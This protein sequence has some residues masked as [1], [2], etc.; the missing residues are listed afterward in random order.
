MAQPINWDELSK[1]VLAGGAGAV[2]E[3]LFG[4]PEFVAKKIDRKKVEDWIKANAPAYHTGEAIGTVGSMFVPYAG[5]A[6]KAAKGLGLGAE[7]AKGAATAAKTAA[8][9]TDLTRGAKLAKTLKTIG[10]MAGKGAAAGATEAGVRGIT[11]EKS[12]KDIAKDIQSGAIWGGAGGAVGGALAKTLPRR[13]GEMTKTAEQAYLGSTDLTRREALQML[14]TWPGRAIR[15]LGNSRRPIMPARN[16]SESEK[17]SEH[18]Y[19][20]KWTMRYLHIKQCGRCL[21]TSSKKQCRMY[22]VRISTARPQAK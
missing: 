17:K 12:L 14:K 18:I 1:S 15:A 9:A 22:A 16:L 10:T 2:D 6:G 21:M 13:A 4:L 3:F 5:L 8:V 11:S 20:A 19:P 7:V